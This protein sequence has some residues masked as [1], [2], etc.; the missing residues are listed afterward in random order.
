MRSF[1]LFVVV[2][3]FSLQ[4]G[5]NSQ[6]DLRR[7]APPSILSPYFTRT[8]AITPSK[9]LPATLTPAVTPTPLIYKI[10]RNDTLSGL[11]KRFGISLEELLAAN[12]GV[13]PEALSV[14][15][16]LTIPAASQATGS[17]FLSTPVPLVPGPG[18]CLPSE[19]GTTCL[20]PVRNPYP[21]A[22]ENVEVQV[23]V[24]DEH[25][26]SLASQAASLPLN[27]LPAGQVL[28]AAVFFSDLTVRTVAQGQLLSAIRLSPADGRYLQTTIQNQ[29]TSISWDGLSADVQG[30]ILLSKTGKPAS[31][32][33]LIAVALGAG[34]QIVGYRRWEWSGSLQPGKA[35]TF[36]L[37]VYS[38]GP[39]I[40]RV[41]VVVEARP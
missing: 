36:K 29:L 16:T 24:F 13:A 33:W 41:D 1:W 28:P 9:P 34:D 20:V 5:C 7:P 23:N 25:G 39:Q 11:A 6:P 38:L 35:R 31:S 40:Q 30:Q 37:S 10:S 14:G 4:T 3:V 21:Q 22:L 18:F 17:T 12:P 19:G 15:Q 27:I 32:L 2:S 8:P 26:Q